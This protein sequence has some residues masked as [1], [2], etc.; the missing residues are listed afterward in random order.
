M[1]DNTQ[2]IIERY[3]ELVQPKRADEV[4][5]V[6]LQAI[7][8]ELGVSD[9]EIAAAEV[10]AQDHATRGRLH[11]EHGLHDDAVREF[12]AAVALRPFDV[13]LHRDLAAA[14]SGR[15]RATGQRHDAEL[16][17]TL[18]RRIIEAS[19]DDREAYVLLE[20]LER[21]LNQGAKRRRAVAGFIALALMSIG[22][23]GYWLNPEPLPPPPSRAQ[24][25]GEEIPLPSPTQGGGE[26]PKVATEQPRE[27]SARAEG[28]VS[29][30]FD[31]RGKLK[32]FGFEATRSRFERYESG[33]LSYKLHAEITNNSGS[34]LTLLTLKFDL[35][36]DDGSTLH[37]STKKV[38]RSDEPPHRP[39]DVLALSHLFFDKDAGRSGPLP[40]ALKVTLSDVV[41][42][43]KVD[44]PEA[45]VLPIS[46]VIEPGAFKLEVRERR[47]R[48]GDSPLL[49]GPDKGK[50]FCELVLEVRNVGQAMSQLKVRATWLGEGGALLGTTERF[51][52]GPV[53]APLPTDTARL[54]RLIGT[55]EAAPVGA[56][57]EV[58]AVK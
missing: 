26:A 30:D 29:V 24:G 9:E 23:V 3:L 20:G 4:D 56:K 15:F 14:L 45:K 13:A 48:A 19:P 49:F 38:L 22:T 6:E 35:I 55:A 47:F 37:T 52:I 8:R 34:A 42:E 50:T 5:Q 33:A 58:I 32:G 12:S 1:A 11:V 57:L 28:D 54:Y 44:Y 40:K 17:K 36:G 25:G 10:A 51:V 41:T 31:H 21:L 39:A 27:P 46:W 2:R 16:A 53:S 7:A 18:A 43:P